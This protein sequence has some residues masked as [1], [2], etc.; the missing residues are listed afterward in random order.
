[1]VY[2]VHYI[3]LI[4]TQVL[5]SVQIIAIS[6]YRF[7]L[8]HRLKCCELNTT[9]SNQVP[10]YSLYPTFG[11][12]FKNDVHFDDDNVGDTCVILQDSMCTLVPSDVP[13]CYHECEGIWNETCTP[14]C[15]LWPESFVDPETQKTSVQYT[16]KFSEGFPYVPKVPPSYMLHHKETI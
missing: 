4:I 3:T 14:K 6:D 12:P 2:K 10:D 13:L 5:L 8:F 9:L 16:Y 11:F 7:T 1:M 15:A